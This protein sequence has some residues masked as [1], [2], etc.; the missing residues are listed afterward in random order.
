MFFDGASLLGSPSTTDPKVN[1]GSPEPGASDAA[2]SSGAAGSS[3]VAGPPVTIRQRARG[4]RPPRQWA[5]HT[6]REVAG[7]PAWA[8]PHRTP[9]H[10]LC[11]QPIPAQ[12]A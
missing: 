6:S 2:G 7:P 3:D 8:R 4:T 10:S 1:K 5:Q 9:T 12:P 11:I